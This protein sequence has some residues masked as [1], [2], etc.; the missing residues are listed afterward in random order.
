MKATLQTRKGMNMK[1]FTLE[2]TLRIAITDKDL[3]M[4]YDN[5]NWSL[6]AGATFGVAIGTAIDNWIASNEDKISDYELSVFHD[7]IVEMLKVWIQVRD[8]E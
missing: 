3:D 4:M 7:D 2:K 8:A 6:L 5:Y 1:E